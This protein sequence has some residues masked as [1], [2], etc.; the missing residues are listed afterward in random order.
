MLW[1]LFIKREREAKKWCP[2]V[3]VDSQLSFD[4]LKKQHASDYLQSFKPKRT[5]V[6]FCNLIT[7]GEKKREKKR[8]EAE[9]E[10]RDALL[11]TEPSAESWTAA[12]S[13]GSWD[14]EMGEG[15]RKRGRERGR[16]GRERERGGRWREEE[17]SRPEE[18]WGWA[19]RLG[20]EWRRKWGAQRA[21]AGR[22]GG[23]R[24][25]KWG[26]VGS[27]KRWDEFPPV[28]W[29]IYLAAG[30]KCGHKIKGPQT[31]RA[32]NTCCKWVTGWMSGSL[33]HCPHPH[34]LLLPPPT[35][36]ETHSCK[37]CGS[38]TAAIPALCKPLEGWRGQMLLAS[39]HWLLGRGRGGGITRRWQRIWMQTL[40][41]E[42]RPGGIFLIFFGCDSEG[43]KTQAII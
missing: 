17:G 37:S 4:G 25:K 33:S 42:G 15:A 16:G 21:E 39:V 20:T 41:E 6:S 18:G 26:G 24:G 27:I 1:W 19:V 28:I 5:Q 22:G 11:I 43:R 13:T 10:R 40:T 14:R 12:N 38:C 3:S 23:G 29:W 31:Q 2:I 9:R 30:K 35:V 36:A 8:G 7:W 32:I 34:P